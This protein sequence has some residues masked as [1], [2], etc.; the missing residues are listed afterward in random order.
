MNLLLSASVVH[1]AETEQELNS[2][3]IPAKEFVHVLC[4]GTE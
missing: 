2:L 3:L 4:T 1:G